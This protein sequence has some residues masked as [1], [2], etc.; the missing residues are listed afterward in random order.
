M[1]KRHS[2]G[3][4]LIEILIAVAIL[5]IIG[6]IAVPSYGSYIKQARR[7]DAQVALRGE[8]Q[9]MERCRTEQFTYVGCSP[10]TDQESPDRY[11]MISFG[12]PT[13]NT[14]TLTATPVSG[15]TQANDTDCPSFTIDQTGATSPADCW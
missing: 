14:Y 2:T 11:Y 3:F 8:A 9:Q 15:K 1:H 6:A 12:T 7:L 5:G 13:A 10:S 4:T